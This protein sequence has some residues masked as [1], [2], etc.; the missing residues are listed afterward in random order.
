LA[1][2]RR[3]SK[4]WGVMVGQR[5]PA[6]AQDRAM[7][8]RAVVKARDIRRATADINQRH[9]QL[10]LFYAQHRFRSRQWHQNNIGDIETGAVATFDDVLCRSNGAGN[11]MDPRLQADP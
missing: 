2:G 10:A 5:V 9:S 1:V 3:V 4:P 11:D 8:S 6:D 7:S